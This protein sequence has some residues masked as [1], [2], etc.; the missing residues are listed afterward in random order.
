MKKRYMLHVYLSRRKENI[1][2]CSTRLSI[3]SQVTFADQV[4]YVRIRILSVK[5]VAGCMGL[6]CGCF[7]SKSVERWQFGERV[8]SDRAQLL[9]A[10]FHF[11][12][13][14]FNVG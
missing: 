5:D 1:C 13:A 9:S 8:T 14:S 2:Y 6:E 4:M 12:N 11:S 7:A 10:A 3:Y